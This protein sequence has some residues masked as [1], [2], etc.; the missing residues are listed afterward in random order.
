L[1]RYRR[2]VDEGDRRRLS[3]GSQDVPAPITLV[4]VASISGESRTPPA[5]CCLIPPHRLST[6]FRHRDTSVFEFST[7]PGGSGSDGLVFLRTDP[8][9]GALSKQDR[10]HTR[11]PRA[12][13]ASP[14]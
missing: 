12:A 10:A 14:R 5:S 9:A 8:P 13:R 4:H 11:P 3:T 2:Y 6:N 1:P 7:S